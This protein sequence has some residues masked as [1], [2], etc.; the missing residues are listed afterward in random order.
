MTNN[1]Q[2][3][4]VIELGKAQDVVLGEKVL[5]AQVD[6]MTGEWGTTYIEAT[7]D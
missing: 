7:G 5:D 4:E 2:G 6:S 1:Y 3:A